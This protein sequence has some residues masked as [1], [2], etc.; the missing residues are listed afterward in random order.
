[1]DELPAIL[2][3]DEA[4]TII[5]SNAQSAPVE[6]AERVNGPGIGV[7]GPGPVIGS[8]AQKALIEAAERANEPGG[9]VVGLPRSLDEGED[10][11]LADLRLA[12]SPALDQGD[13]GGD[14]SQGAWGVRSCRGGAVGQGERDGS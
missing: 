10:D 2:G 11:G 14:R 9:R 1:M 8:N 3:M 13:G 12:L 4:P 6:A 5:G 7:K